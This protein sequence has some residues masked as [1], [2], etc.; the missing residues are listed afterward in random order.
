VL[1]GIASHGRPLARGGAGTGPTPAFFDY[2]LTT[3]LIVLVGLCVLAAVALVSQRAAL[4]R[5][6]RSPWHILR[7]LLSLLAAVLLATALAR[8]DFGR[9]LR[10]LEDGLNAAQQARTGRHDR[11][12][13][14]PA[15]RAHV[16]WDE[17][18]LVLALLAGAGVVLA[19][20]RGRVLRR[21]PAPAEE[22]VAEA[23]DESI[24]DLRGDVDLRRAIIAAYARM[25]R[26]LAH[27]GLPRRPA[28]APFEYV[29]RAL[30]SLDADAGAV[31]R[32]TSLFE[33][34]RFS[35]HD[36]SPAMRD[37]AIAALVAVRERLR[38][39]FA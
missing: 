27:A 37:E 1:A 11:P 8:S 34:A 23:L 30:G 15:H 19:A 16:R 5:P 14:Q 10:Q 3:L 32:L 22:L 4:R 31:R 20:G 33:W 39:A 25:E 7:V 6:E 28:E 21:L 26:A 12:T 24:D 18:A 9:R 17:I 36:P 35:Q 29:E 2:A 38:G 13:A